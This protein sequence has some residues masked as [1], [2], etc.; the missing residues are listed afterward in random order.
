MTE[1]NRVVSSYAVV[2]CDSCGS[3]EVGPVRDGYAS[4]HELA[5]QLADIR[6]WRVYVGR[7]RRNYCPACGPSRGHRMRLVRGSE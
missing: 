2:T 6:G 1:Q 4:P 3:E 7:E 5:D